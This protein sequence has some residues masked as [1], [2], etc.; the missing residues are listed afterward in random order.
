MNAIEDHLHRLAAGTLPRE[1]LYAILLEQELIVPVD[2]PVQPAEAG[3][4]GVK[5]LCAVD[6]EGYLAAGL[7]T[8]EQCWPAGARGRAISSVPRAGRCSPCWRR[9]PCSGST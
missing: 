7:F 5:V 4:T 6:Q 1:P 3:T 9:C 8:S 2:R